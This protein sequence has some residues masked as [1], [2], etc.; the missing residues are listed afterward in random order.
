MVNLE[1][2]L[3]LKMG[4]GAG[5]AL[6]AGG[7]GLA[8]YKRFGSQERGVQVQNSNLDNVE[9]Y[10]NGLIMAEK[11]KDVKHV[12]YDNSNE[13]AYAKR[14][15]D[16]Y[17]KASASRYSLRLDEPNILDEVAGLLQGH[18]L[19]A[20]RTPEEVKA[21]IR[22]RL[23]SALGR[24]R[25]N[26]LIEETFKKKLLTQIE[27]GQPVAIRTPESIAD[28]RQEF[29]IYVF[30]SIFQPYGINKTGIVTVTDSM[31]SEIRT[32]ILGAYSGR[33]TAPR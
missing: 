3:L 18:K 32:K 23:P 30:P 4:V 19:Y 15:A 8:A 16:N 20:F 13:K 26:G 7:L 12:T 9:E 5:A 29:E 17:A 28:G 6:G 27:Q 22:N 24:E 21:G 31:S 1:R 33:V 14:A 11:P 2:R 25:L 10:L